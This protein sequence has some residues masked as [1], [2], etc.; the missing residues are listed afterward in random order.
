M[1]GAGRRVRIKGREEGGEDWREKGDG[2]RIKKTSMLTNFSHS[3]NR[4]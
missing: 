3:P 1:D 4:G 2:E